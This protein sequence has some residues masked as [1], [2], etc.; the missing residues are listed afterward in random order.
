MEIKNYVED[1]CLEIKCKECK[2]KRRQDLSY[3]GKS[4]QNQMQE[5]R[6]R[7]RAWKER[8]RGR[9][10]PAKASSKAKN[11]RGQ[12]STKTRMIVVSLDLGS[13]N[14]GVYG[15]QK[16]ARLF[17]KIFSKEKRRTVGIK[18][19]ELAIQKPEKPISWIF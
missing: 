14:K 12:R 9:Q 18:M 13:R 6:R 2:A 7:V 17:C 16:D 19:A 1:Y 15:K 11:G 4:L 8:V 3:D 5:P 10:T